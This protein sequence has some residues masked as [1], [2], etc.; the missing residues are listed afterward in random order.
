MRLNANPGFVTAALGGLAAGYA[1]HQIRAAKRERNS[2]D[3]QLVI[4][5]DQLL[6]PGADY[7][8]IARL[9]VNEREPVN[10]TPLI[11]DH[12]GQGVS[13]IEQPPQRPG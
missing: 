6:R 11:N 9:S 2:I 8:G 3:A 12:A 10:G 7:L 1:C 4:L 5:L 13:V